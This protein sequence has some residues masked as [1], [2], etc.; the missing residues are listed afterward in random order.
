MLNWVTID[1]YMRTPIYRAECVGPVKGE[2]QEDDEIGMLLSILG[3]FN[4]R[5]VK[6][7]TRR[8]DVQEG[9][10]S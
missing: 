5:Q 8:C 10:R 4:G 9:S 2:A 1:T 3:R 7:Q 6:I